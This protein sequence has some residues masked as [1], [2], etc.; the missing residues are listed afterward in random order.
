VVSSESF[1]SGYISEDGVKLSTT[2]SDEGTAAG[3][4]RESAH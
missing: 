2:P 4:W 3:G 1:V